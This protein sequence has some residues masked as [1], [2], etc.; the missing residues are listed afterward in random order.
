[1]IRHFPTKAVLAGASLLILAGCATPPSSE[2]GFADVQRTIGERL[3]QRISW[4]Q[5][6]PEDQQ[7]ETAVRQLLARPL[8]ADDAVQV[9]LLRN[10]G[11]QASY[12]EIGLAQ[13][14]LVQAGLLSNP[15][16]SGQTRWSSQG[17]GPNV[18]FG[19]V[20]NFLTL[21]M[22]PGQ[23]RIADAKFG[24]A[25]AHVAA[26]VVELAAEI[27]KAW[28]TAAGAE[29][30]AE[31][32]REG[33]R[34]AQASVDLS[35]RML[36]AGNVSELAHAREQ[37]SFEQA[38]IELTRAEAEA[39]AARE[40]LIR[41]LG[42][43]GTETGIRT[44]ARLPDLVAETLPLDRLETLAVERNLKLAASVADAKGIA[45]Q[46]GMVRDF[47]WLG[48]AEI[49]I[50]RERETGG[51]KLTGPSVSIP[52][53]IFD[54]GQARTQTASAQLRQAE[55]RLLQQAIDLRSEVREQRERIIRTRYLADHYRKV[56]IPLQQ[57]IVRLGLEQ[58]NYM[59]IGVFDVLAARQNEL[60]TYRSYIDAVRD[61]W[62]ARAE[63]DRALGGTL[64]PGETRPI[65]IA[66]QAA[67]AKTAAAAPAAHK[68]H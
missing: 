20:Q 60:T 41:L 7:L 52:L 36:A 50:N 56:V 30:L 9:G 47:A 45:Q 51:E 57:R 1:M 58:Y 25:K 48:D 65:Q 35:D 18:E 8:S 16:F 68:G 61:H 3:P 42:L 55:H 29:Q 66:P 13:A 26:E 10:R 44:T 40:K 19:L 2:A 4:R 43:S 15:V 34:G 14:D 49:G 59:L 39:A 33:A 46:L 28:L 62:I 22:L 54:F 38:R 67:P 23:Q 37:A 5:N 17:G 12:E 27:R 6:G 64:P 24:A 32:L 11:L 63:L 21:L 31:V 53:P